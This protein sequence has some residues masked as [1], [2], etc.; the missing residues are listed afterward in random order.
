MSTHI[1]VSN[2]NNDSCDKI[3]IRLQKVWIICR[4]QNTIS[5]VGKEEVEKGCIITLG[6][7]YNQKDKVKYLLDNIKDD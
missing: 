1:S 6:P 7:P 3:L 4:L 2:K 5:I